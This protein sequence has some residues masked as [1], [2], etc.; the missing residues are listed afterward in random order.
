MSYDTWAVHD[1]SLSVDFLESQFEKE[2]D[3]IYDTI[4]SLVEEL[5]CVDAN[6][7]PYLIGEEPLR[8]RVSVQSLIE[9]WYS[10]H[11][12]SAYSEVSDEVEEMLACHAKQHD[13]SGSCPQELLLSDAFNS[14]QKSFSVKFPGMAI[15]PERY[16]EE[17]DYP[18][19]NSPDEEFYLSLQ[20]VMAKSQSA[21]AIEQIYSLAITEL[22]FVQGG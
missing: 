2:I 18:Y 1:Y 7:Y 21:I 19:S 3:N 10:L 20:G 8:E 9:V 13:S 15:S 5:G 17:S 12:G 22:S 16:D 14:L 11:H 4:S 6:D